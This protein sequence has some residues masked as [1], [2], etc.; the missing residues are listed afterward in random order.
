MTEDTHNDLT[1]ERILDQAERLFSQKDFAAVSMRE[2]TNAAGCNLG[3]VNYHFG[4]K[5]NLYLEVFRSRWIPRAKRAR[6]SLEKLVAQK[7]ELPLEEILAM[8]TSGFMYA[9]SSPEDRKLHFGLM[10]REMSSPGE[11]FGLVLEQI[12]TPAFSLLESLIGRHL[13]DAVSREQRM[14]AVFSIMGQILYFNMASGLIQ[15]FTGRTQ[16]QELT[17][18]MT[19]HIARFSHDGLKG[20]GLGEMEQ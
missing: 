19:R 11:A 18:D 17:N 14:L 12:I 13:A 3:A 5:Q 16:G 8:A 1:R 15:K 6:A 4:S 10:M 9:F 20:L 7:P 2:L